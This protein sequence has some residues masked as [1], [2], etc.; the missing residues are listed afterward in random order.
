MQSYANY[1]LKTP[2]PDSL[3]WLHCKLLKPYLQ[4]SLDLIK[5]G[6]VL[7]RLLLIKE[8][9]YRIPGTSVNKNDMI[10]FGNLVISMFLGFKIRISGVSIERVKETSTE[11]RRKLWACMMMAFRISELTTVFECQS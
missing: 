3:R 7:I 10:C 2:R 5:N 8:Y 1:M 4:C 9:V 11:V 6:S